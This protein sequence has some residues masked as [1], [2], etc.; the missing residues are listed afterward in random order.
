ME[1]LRTGLE[2]SGA[3]AS[4]WPHSEQYGD[5]LRFAIVLPGHLQKT[6]AL[7]DS[8][9]VPAG[10]RNGSNLKNPLSLCHMHVSMMSNQRCGV[11]PTAAGWEDVRCI[12]LCLRASRRAGGF[13]CGWLH[14]ATL[15]RS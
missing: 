8:T 1:G 15:H 9:S 2:A 13:S 14:G 11:T 7:S 4:A 5:E 10:H 12:G 3:S 6:Y